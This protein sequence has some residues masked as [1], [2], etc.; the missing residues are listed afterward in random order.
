MQGLLVL[1]LAMSINGVKV[2]A[3]RIVPRPKADGETAKASA[4]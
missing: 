2:D 3:W 1:L 4:A